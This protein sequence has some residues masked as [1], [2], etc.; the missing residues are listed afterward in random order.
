MFL[1]VA[2]P[3]PQETCILLLE[4]SCRGHDGLMVEEMANSVWKDANSV[5]N[6]NRPRAVW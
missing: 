2:G 1:E 6:L 4:P 5:I 3:K